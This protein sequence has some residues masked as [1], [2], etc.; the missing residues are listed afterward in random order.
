MDAA[1]ARERA[2]RRIDV[3][4]EVAAFEGRVA[5]VCGP[6]FCGKTE[7]LVRRVAA[8]AER[9]TDAESVLVEV[10]SAPAAREFERRI[11]AALG[12]D[13]A[14]FRAGLR[15]LTP[16]EACAQVLSDERAR[17]RTGRIP[18][19]LTPGEYAFFLEDMKTLGQPVRRLRAMLD[20]FFERWSMLDDEQDWLE[21]GE[22]GRARVHMAR[23]L[24]REGAMLVQEAAYVCARYL[25]SDEGAAACG[26]YDYVLCDDY[27]NMSRAQQ[28]CLCLMA[29]KQLIV[30]GNPD[31]EAP[32]AG[33]VAFAQGFAE[34]ET[35]RRGVDVFEL[36]GSHAA[37]A[38]AAF[39]EA[40]R[41]GGTNPFI[42]APANDD[43]ALCVKWNSPEEELEGISA[44]IART[45]RASEGAESPDVCVVVPDRRWARMAGAALERR[46]LRPAF[47]PSLGG[48]RGDY[49]SPDRSRALAAYTAALLLADEHDAV[50]W[51]CWCGFG[52]HIANSDAWAS[53]CSYADERGQTLPEAL[54]SI[55]LCAQGGAPEPFLRAAALAARYA[56]GREFIERNRHRSGFSALDAAGIEALPEFA[57]FVQGLDGDE[58]ASEIGRALHAWALDPSYPTR[59]SYD[60]RIARYGDMTGLA[61]DDLFA[62]AAVDGLMPVRDAFEAVSTDEARMRA[63]DSERR[64]FYAAAA[65]A[66]RRLVLSFFA[67]SPLELAERARM[68]VVRVRAAGNDRVASLRPSSFL[69]EAGAALPA[70]V[71]GQALLSR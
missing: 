67:R 2:S 7:A 30:A 21:P 69:A 37:P 19:F 55:E 66:R 62:I 26:G 47:G 56:E 44:L 33:A 35:L 34:F 61:A 52:N 10:A 57:D 1:R 22:E 25:Q 9:G 15:V 58:S 54:A 28:V 16:L 38:A 53:L 39:A 48:V 14:A 51:R 68:Q 49:R 4:D 36:E 5:K 17:A 60:V 24:E 64:L 71:G 40:V 3:P 42:S 31:E 20:F 41:A 50:A 46:G 27:Q 8:L 65:K 13:G 11:A 29:K 23:L 70:T 12:P 43:E 32:C 18:R 63:M 59:G 45:V 6:A